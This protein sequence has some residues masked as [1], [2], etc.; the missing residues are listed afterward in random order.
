MNFQELRLLL[1]YHY[2]ARDRMFAAVE[3]LPSDQYNKDLG[4]SFKSI[5]DTLVHFYSA[6]VVWC[7]RWLGESPAALSSAGVFADFNALRSSWMAHE[8]RMRTFLDSLGED[9]VHRV[10]EYKSFAGQ[11]SRQPYWQM[12]QHVVNHASYHRG[13][14]TTMIRQLKADPPASMDLI[15]FY[16]ERAS[17]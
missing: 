4:G 9:G 5:H 6:E 16:R 17:G 11:P 8:L 14:V 10:I 1:D 2:W 15:A 12:L 13:Q 7:S 3:K